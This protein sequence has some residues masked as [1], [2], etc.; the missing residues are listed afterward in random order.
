MEN[1]STVE[2]EAYVIQFAP[3]ALKTYREERDTTRGEL[4]TLITIYLHPTV[5]Y[6]SWTDL[7]TLIAHISLH[8]HFCVLEERDSK[9]WTVSS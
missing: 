5:T 4:M 7:F 9:S 8:D 1:T 6:L 2:E 3:N